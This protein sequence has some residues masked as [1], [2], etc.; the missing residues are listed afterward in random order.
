[1]SHK[2]GKSFVPNP[3]MTTLIIGITCFNCAQYLDATGTCTNSLCS[4]SPDACKPF[5]DKPVTLWSRTAKLWSKIKVLLLLGLAGCSSEPTERFNNPIY[6]CTMRPYAL[7][8]DIY[9]PDET[10]AEGQ[11]RLI[12]DRMRFNNYEVDCKETDK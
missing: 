8:V 4:F 3:S 11:A 5:W 1:M 9:A 12:G 2:S 6:S 10:T 7:K